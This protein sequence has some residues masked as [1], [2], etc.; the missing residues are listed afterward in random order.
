MINRQS[1]TLS[2][3][4]SLENIGIFLISILLSIACIYSLKLISFLMPLIS[5]LVVRSQGG[6]RNISLTVTSPI[7]ILFLL[8]IWVGMTT[9]WTS[10]PIPALKTF[11]L[12]CSILLFSILLISALTKANPELIDRGFKILMISGFFL[13]V[14]ITIQLC[15][16]IFYIKLFKGSSRIYMMKPTGSILGLTVFVGSG[17]L[18]IYGFRI[19]SLFNWFLLI[20]FIYLTLSQ[21][22]FYGVLFASL[23][24][25]LSYAMPF[26]ITRFSM[27]SSYTFL[28]LSPLLYTYVISPDTLVNV[29]QIK[30]LLNR[31]I[32]SR[33]LAWKYYSEKFFEQPFLGWG[34]ESARFLPTEPELA[35]GY[36]NLLHPHNNSIQVYSELGIIGGILFALF[37]SSLFWLIEKHVK[38]RL[39]V[40]V[41]NA[42]LAFGFFAAEVTHNIWRSYWLSLVALVTGLL[43]LF[44]KAREAQLRVEADHLK[45]SPVL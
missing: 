8:L 13:I 22:A 6:I 23:I 7:V 38:D 45:Q 12:L 29:H 42:T 3:F 18:W 16:D 10:Y 27:I 14:L 17:F 31:S 34:V 11:I 30:G 44:L 20:I 35:P 24:F 9:F 40:A 26:W 4:V 5:I 2:R 39:S 36:I 37:F 25:I 28:I 19:L 41:C 43:I 15:A 21:T 1:V 32:F 33:V